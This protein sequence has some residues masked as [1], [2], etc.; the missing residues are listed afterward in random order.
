[1][2]IRFIARTTLAMS[3]IWCFNG[4]RDET[5]TIRSHKR[6]DKTADLAAITIAMTAIGGQKA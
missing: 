3:L 5:K 1:M 6:N 4:I 2:I